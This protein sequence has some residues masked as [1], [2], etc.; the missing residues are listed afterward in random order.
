ML[1]FEPDLRP[2][3]TIG[4]VAASTLIRAGS[5]GACRDAMLGVRLVTGDGQ[6]VKNGGRVMKNV[7]GYDLVKLLAGSRGTLGAITEIAFRPRRCR[8]CAVLRLDGLDDASAI[9]AMTVALAGPMM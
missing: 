6:I 3:S 4:G 9:A 5:R 8:P 2:G 7:T 1:G